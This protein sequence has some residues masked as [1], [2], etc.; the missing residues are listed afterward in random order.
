[1]IKMTEL[2]NDLINRIREQ[3]DRDRITKGHIEALKKFDRRNKL[4]NLALTT[5]KEQLQKM[6]KF[7]RTVNKEFDDVNEIDLENF[8]VHLK[9]KP[10]T[11][12]SWK[13][14]LKKWYKDNPK[15]A[16]VE[17]LKKSANAYKFKKPSEMLSED[18]VRRMVDVS[19]GNQ[20]KA[21]VAVLWDCGPRVGEL[22]NCNISDLVNRGDHLY[23]SV[24]GKTG[25]RELGLVTSA[26]LMTRWLDEHPFREQPDKPLFISFNN[27]R[28]HERLTPAGVADIVT[29]A[30]QKAGISK[31]VTPH[32]FRH[33]KAT[34]LGQF[35][36][37]T[38]LRQFFG[39]SRNS[40][41]PGVYIHL[42]QTHVN[43]KRR[44][45]ETG[46]K[47]KQE[48]KRSKLMSIPCPRCGVE[49]DSSSK[50]CSGCMLPLSQQSVRRDLKILN[51][52]RSPYM[53]LLGLDV[54]KYVDRF[55]KFRSLVTEMVTFRKAFNGDKKMNINLLRNE[56]GWTKQR[57][58]DMLNYLL[59]TDVVKVEEDMVE[60]QIFKDDKGHVKSV[61]DNFITLERR[62]LKDE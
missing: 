34:H 29:K 9:V 58:N 47:P 39:W 2:V 50:Y 52:F 54:D 28:F 55:Y 26:S 17:C 57:F 30:K 23:L 33:S 4:R 27:A 8:L 20:A 10:Y 42:T 14:I 16:D 18:E 59:E 6:L 38:E 46:E 60:I 37:E 49:N 53:K 62:F 43:D 5:R 24:D 12:E 56:L 36:T 3:K 1:M 61:F 13:I 32:I 45:I 21:I 41:M 25:I 51:T 31:R 48:I 44:L 11:L 40:N 7:A 22:V 15:I 35:M 19:V